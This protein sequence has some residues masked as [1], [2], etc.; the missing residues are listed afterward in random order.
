MVRLEKLWNNISGLIPAG[1]VVG[2][3][4]EHENLCRAYKDILN[5]L[6]S[7]DGWKPTCIPA[8]LNE[9]AQNRF[10]AMEMD[11]LGAK[12]QIEEWIKNPGRELKE[13]R[14]RFTQKRRQLVRDAI[15]SICKDIDGVLKSLS[16]QYTDEDKFGEYIGKTPIWQALKDYIDE[17]NVLIG[18]SI[19]RPKSWFEMQ[20]H[21]HFGQVNDLWNICKSDWPEIKNFIDTAIYSDDEP[22]PT[23]VK[24][25]NDIISSKPSGPVAI[26]L[27]WERIDAEDFERLIFSL[28]GS[29]SSYEN[30]EWLMKT[31]AQD[32]GRDV[33]AYRVNVDNLA[34][35]IRKRVIIQCK[36]WLSKSVSLTDISSLKEE[37]KLWE[38]PRV[39]ILIIATS[40]RFT[41][42][43]VA[44]VERNNQSDTSLRIEMWPESHLERLVAT[45]PY[46]IAEFNLREMR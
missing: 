9:I 22:I 25:I 39:D 20:R 23:R 37:I 4:E 10:D 18:D 38:P 6:P 5:E 21:L 46:L 17:L 3:N 34:G 40:G 14:Y 33:S 31:M 44:C 30:P 42:D 24:D 41:S 27:A 2:T 29:E 12:I 32:K 1:L 45:R 8:E 26:K 28:I 7:I 11:E 15:S 19:K 36:H 13:Y 35:V 16:S 43:A